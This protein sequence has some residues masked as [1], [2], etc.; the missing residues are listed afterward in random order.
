MAQVVRRSLLVREVWGLNHEPIKSPTR[1][2]RLVT[3]ANF[4]VWSLV[5]NREDGHR[6][7]VTP[8]RVLSEYNE[9][10]ISFLFIYF[11]VN[12]HKTDSWS[13]NSL[14]FTVIIR[15]VH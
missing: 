4:E 3:A 13:N 8:E 6:S 15:S 12:C 7:L 14:T 11:F 10:C 9:N 5:Q 2:Q 1:C